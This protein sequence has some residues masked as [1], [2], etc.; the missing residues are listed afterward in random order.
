MRR[1]NAILIG[2]LVLG[3]MLFTSCGD[4]D[5][6][7]KEI[8]TLTTQA[9][10]DAFSFSEGMKEV[11][12]SGETVNDLSGLDIA[13]IEVLK[14]EGT[15]VTDIILSDLTS[16]SRDFVIDDNDLLQ[17]VDNLPLFTHAYG[18]I[19]IENND[20]L[21]SISGFKHLQRVGGDFI[22]RNNPLLG[23]DVNCKA[24][25]GGFCFIKE[26]YDQGGIFVGDIILENNHPGAATDVSL[27]GSLASGGIIDYTL[28]SQE[29]V[30]LFAP[31]SDTVGSLTLRGQSITDAGRLADLISLVKGVLTIENTSLLGTEAD[32]GS[33]IDAVQLD[34]SV[35]I[36]DNPFLTNPNGFRFKTVIK[37][38][39][40]VVNNPMLEL[41]WD[42]AGFYQVDS[43]YG[44]LVFRDNAKLH[45]GGVII[46]GLDYV[47]GDFEITNSG[48]QGYDLWNIATMDGIKYIGGDLIIKDNPYFNR[49]LGLQYLEYVGGD[50]TFTNNGTHEN[51][52]GI[53]LDRDEFG[54]GFCLI[55]ELLDSGVI[56]A[57]ATI[58]LVDHTGTTLDVASLAGCTSK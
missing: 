4:P 26:K 47:G 14:I 25:G 29:D 30:D 38:D 33:F 7:V 45:N 19:R 44:D 24:E 22:V 56:Q 27:I 32:G 10:V 12:I 41:G 42:P 23:E 43:V 35:I 16:I 34:S 5:P 17:T 18:T 2:S 46:K 37:G 3:A 9:E 15:G 1:K 21:V 40:I 20:V 6:E 13:I 52:G 50:V 28:N 53:P 58:E 36:K 51:A 49:L 57:G 8:V 31:E 54:H 11:H 48:S 39:L 55:R